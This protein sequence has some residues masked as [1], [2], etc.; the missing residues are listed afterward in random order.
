MKTKVA[1]H[2]VGKFPLLRHKLPKA[3]VKQKGTGQLRQEDPLR[4]PHLMCLSVPVLVLGKF[5]FINLIIVDP[6]ASYAHLPF[7]SS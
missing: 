1:T 4:A 6:Q 3:S 2:N 7:Q 5:V